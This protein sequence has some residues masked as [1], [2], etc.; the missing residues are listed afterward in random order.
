MFGLKLALLFGYNLFM[1]RGTIYKN[2]QIWCQMHFTGG[3]MNCVATHRAYPQY[4]QG[5]KLPTT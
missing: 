4:R 5:A 3:N 2:G 1:Q